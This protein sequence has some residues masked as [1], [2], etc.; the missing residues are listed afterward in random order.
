MAIRTDL[1]VE[2][3]E[4]Y[5][6]FE[7]VKELKTTKK[8]LKITRIEIETEE[9]AA[10]LGKKVGR[11]VT[12]EA[13]RLPDID[14]EPYSHIPEVLESELAPFFSGA[15]SY[16]IV[17]LGNRCV[18]ADSLGPEVADRML[19][20]RHIV[21]YLPEAL[22]TDTPSVSAVTPGVLGTTG[23]ETSELARAAVECVKP[24][25]VIAVDSLAAL[26]TNRIAAAVQFSNTG[27]APGSGV[28]NIRA[29]LEKETL[30]AEVIAIGAPLVVYASTIVR[31][32][33][34]VDAA[35]PKDMEELVVTPKEIDRLVRISADAIAE[36]ISRAI[37][38]SRYEELKLLIQ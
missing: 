6:S 17:G 7:G 26:K 34:G 13:R 22:D 15:S 38:G 18:T 5:P 33:A 36:G 20:T 14:P 32:T 3:R 4:L 2:A 25:I 29:G 27:I 16:L 28:G 30:G 31:E 9:A 10:K 11:Y 24:D 35:I 37:F 12:V 8:G 21:K 19:V 23:I 1:A